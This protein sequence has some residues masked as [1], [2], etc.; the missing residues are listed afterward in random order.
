[1]IDVPEDVPFDVPADVPL[2][3][4]QDVAPDVSPDGPCPDNDHDGWTTCDGDCDDNN[5]LVNPGAYDFPNGIDDDCDGI[6]D[7][8]MQDCSEGLAYSSQNPH[9][10]AL[11]IEICQDTTLNP[12][13]PMKRWGLLSSAFHLADGTGTPAPQAHSIITSF[14]NVLTPHHGPNMAYIS[15]GVAATP[16]QQYFMAGTTPQPGE[17]MLPP[18]PLNGGYALPPGFPT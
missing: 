8:T 9:D 13:L 18:G 3:V 10:Y 17:A 14:G 6:V 12:P 5:P 2:D 15:T 16:T 11:A 1:P 7:D 4:T